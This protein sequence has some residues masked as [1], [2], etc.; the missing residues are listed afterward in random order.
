VV[1]GLKQP[2]SGF[3]E[4]LGGVVVGQSGSLGLELGEGDAGL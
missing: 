1:D 2:P 4:L 3:V